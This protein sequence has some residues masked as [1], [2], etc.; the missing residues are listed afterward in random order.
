MFKLQLHARYRFVQ[1]VR[2]IRNFEGTLQ[3]IP[4][5]K[6]PRRY[7][8]VYVINMAEMYSSISGKNVTYAVAKREFKCSNPT[9]TIV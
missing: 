8:E 4:K 1:F 2:W 3:R 5:S 6:F 9:G 7:E